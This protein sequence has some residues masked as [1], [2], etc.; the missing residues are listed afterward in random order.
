V[1]NLSGRFDAFHSLDN[2]KQQRIIKSALA[3]FGAKGFKR[4]S[5][6]AIAKNA[7]IGKGMLFYYFTSKEELFNFLCE[8]AIEFARTEYLKRYSSTA[9]DFLERYTAL[10]ELKRQSMAKFSEVTGF[11]ESFYREENAPYVQKFGRDIAEIRELVYGK[12]YDGIDHS[13]FRG[14]L[15]GAA[16]IKYLQWLLD[17]YEKDA[18]ERYNSGGVNVANETAVAEEWRKFYAFVSDLRRIFYREDSENVNY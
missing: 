5:T 11:F 8:Y 16:V 9:G 15:D 13:L 3:E 18:A 17:A 7:Q 6:D 12:V 4:A 14:D 2:E 10:T 1:V